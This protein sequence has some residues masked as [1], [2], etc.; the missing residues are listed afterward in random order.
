MEST[1]DIIAWSNRQ[2]ESLRS[3][4]ATFDLNDDGLLDVDELRDLLS[5]IHQ[6]AE[7][8]ENHMKLTA[9][10]QALLQ[11]SIET[12]TTFSMTSGVTF[13]EFVNFY[14]SMQEIGMQLRNMDTDS[15]ETQ[16]DELIDDITEAAVKTSINLLDKPLLKRSASEKDKFLAVVEER[17]KLL[18]RQ[19]TKNETRHHD[20]VPNYNRRESKDNIDYITFAESAVALRHFRNTHYNIE[21][22]EDIVNALHAH[23]ADLEEQKILSRDKANFA[24]S[25]VDKRDMTAIFAFYKFSHNDV[26]LRSYLDFKHAAIEK[27]AALHRN[28]KKREKYLLERAASYEAFL[29][30][31]RNLLAATKPRAPPI[32]SESPSPPQKTKPVATKKKKKKPRWALLYEDAVRRITAVKAFEDKK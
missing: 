26:A 27:Q 17:R 16:A 19:I 28:K 9:G 32:R 21:L 18:H 4:F 31:R 11:G 22:E 5:L 24:K 14:N 25:L 20:L 8:E 6:N 2:E 15:E 7:D 3:L 1:F 13:S 30:E 10:Q 12:I 29:E 23:F